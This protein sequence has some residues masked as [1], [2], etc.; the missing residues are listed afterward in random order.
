MKEQIEEVTKR[1]E[2]E[3][4]RTPTGKLRELLCDANILLQA[5][6]SGNDSTS[7]QIDD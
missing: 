5:L 6:N 3:I 4:N 1:L 2:I 7:K